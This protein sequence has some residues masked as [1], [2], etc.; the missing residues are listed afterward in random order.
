MKRLIVCCDGTWNDSD[1]GT[2]FTNVARIGW[3]VAPIDGRNGANIP[4][5]CFYQ[6]GVGTGVDLID[7]LVG[8]GI[9]AG[10]AR[11]VRDAYSFIASN[12]CDGDELFL[13][14]FSRGAYTARSI[15]GLIGWAGLLHKADMDRFA[16]LWE[17]FKLR[18][19]PGFT[20][21]RADFNRHEEVPV[22]CVGVWDTV[23]ALGIPGHLPTPFKKL[24]QFLDT[25]LGPRIRHAFH[26]V[27]L[28]EH[29]S[30]FAPTLWTQLP[31]QANA[32]VLEQC[33][34]AGAHANV[35]GGY[36]AHGLSDVTLAWMAA[37]VM[38]LLALDLDQLTAKQ[39]RRE[40]WAEDAI[41]DSA[42]GVWK[43]L[44]TMDRK[45]FAPNPLGATNEAIH[46][47]VVERLAALP[48]YRP[49]SLDHVDAVAKAA[50]LA[51]VEQQLRWIKTAA[52]A[53]AITP[54]IFDLALRH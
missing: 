39:D 52:P 33:W 16:V 34:F 45:P 15:A 1:L 38:P 14:G 28:D 11:N 42:H 2:G 20:D 51:G 54:K 37:K 44:G 53:T 25:S 13:F 7:K 32:Q 31:E 17:S 26:A 21:A 48:D 36:E 24:Y 27:A 50:P 4:Q 22:Q 6:S 35:G 40:P 9:G 18:D 10:L 3:A 41:V 30:D 8:G 29:R 46:A 43:L 49:R 47:S 5:I 23:G 12:Y 19:K